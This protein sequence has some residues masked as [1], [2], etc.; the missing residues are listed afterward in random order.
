MMRGPGRRAVAVRLASGGVRVE[1]TPGQPWH[2]RRSWYGWPIVRGLISLAETVTIGVGALLVSANLSE[3]P[4]EHLGRGQASLAIAV[5]AVMA[6]LLFVVLPTVLVNLLRQSIASRLW[7]NLSEGLVRVGILTFYLAAISSLPEVR[8]MLAY[9]GAEHQAIH[10]L[11]QGLSLDVEEVRTQPRVHPR[12]GT[13][14]L[15]IVAL[16]SILLFSFFGWPGVWQRIALRLAL[17]PVVAGVSYE[18]IRLTGRSRAAWVRALSWPG[19]ALQRLTTRVPDDAQ[20]E[21][22]VAA[23]RAVID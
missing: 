5:A 20:L 23:L 14:F 10:A 18:V 9:H 17:L 13:S 3:D 11:E 19:L 6:V 21:V 8:R 16:M 22:A 4:E 15:L 2:T 12:C 1:V 7:L